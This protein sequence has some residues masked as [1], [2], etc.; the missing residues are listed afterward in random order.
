MV[1]T[2]VNFNNI[3]D[4]FAIR[5][6]VNSSTENEKS[7]AKKRSQRKWRLKNKKKGLNIWIFLNLNVESPNIIR[8]P[9]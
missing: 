6:I 5:I 7:E 8:I 2:G 3:F 9:A 1:K 4:K